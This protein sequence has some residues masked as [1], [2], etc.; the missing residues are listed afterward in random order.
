MPYIKSY[1]RKDIDFKTDHL[2]PRC[3]GELNYLFSMIAKQYLENTGKSYQTCND[4]L[5]A[6]DGASKEFYRRVVAPYED[7]KLK[8]NGDVY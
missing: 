7:E 2:N 8:E 1:I 5:G 6:L 4:V 3:A